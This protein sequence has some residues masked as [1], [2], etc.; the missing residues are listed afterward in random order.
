MDEGKMV[1][2]LLILP[3]CLR[4]EQIERHGHR[5][6]VAQ[7]SL[8]MWFVTVLGRVG[9]PPFLGRVAKLFELAERG[10]VLWNVTR[11]GLTRSAVCS[12]L[13]ADQPPPWR[14]ED[15]RLFSQPSTTLNAANP[16]PFK[17]L[18]SRSDPRARRRHL[19]I[20]LLLLR[21]KTEMST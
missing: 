6:L 7:R 21:G 18:T 12:S 14:S 15:Y 4:Q 1:G 19:Y 9:E 3:C 10:A 8:L 11:P 16:T 13:L 17:G 2:W 20:N 5:A